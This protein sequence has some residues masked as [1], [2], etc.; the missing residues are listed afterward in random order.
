MNVNE[1]PAN[2]TSVNNTPANDAPVNNVTAQHTPVI[3]VRSA[4]TVTGRPTEGSARSVAKRDVLA[5]VAVLAAWIVPG[6]GH[7]MLGRWGRALGFLIA[8][9]GLAITGAVLRGNI[10]APHSGDLF[11]TLGFLADAASGVCYYA[12]RLLETAGSNVS[13][14]AG[15]YGTRFIAAAGVVNLLAVIDALEIASARRA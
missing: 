11:G 8:V 14:A 4:P 3:P 13:R 15:D 10:F 5:P 1:S 2:G 9:A 7:L 12:A 6:A